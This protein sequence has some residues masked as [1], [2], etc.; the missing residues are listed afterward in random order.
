MICGTIFV[1]VTVGV[2]EYAHVCVHL[3][4]WALKSRVRKFP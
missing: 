4:V 3:C 1:H 2:Y